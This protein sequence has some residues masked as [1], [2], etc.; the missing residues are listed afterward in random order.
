MSTIRDRAKDLAAKIWIVRT[1]EDLYNALEEALRTEREILQ[2]EV[3]EQSGSCVLE[4]SDA[5]CPTA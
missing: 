5:C 3:A 1:P 4:D 2:A